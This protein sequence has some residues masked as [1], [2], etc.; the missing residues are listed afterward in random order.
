MSAPEAMVGR[1]DARGRL[2]GAVRLVVR[3]AV[4]IGFFT[5]PAV[6]LW[7][8]VWTG[9]PSSTLTCACGDPAQ[10]VWFVAWPAWAL[11]HLANPFFSGSVNVPFGANL[12]SNTSG[13]LIG[14]VL[15]PVTWVWGPVT[16]TNVALTLAPGLSAWGC[17]VA[18][19]RLVGWKP[20]A[21]PAA[22]VFGYSSAIVT[23]LIFAHASVTLLVIPPLLFAHFHQICIR[24]D[25][26]ALH[27]G[28]VLALLVVIQF[29]ISPE[30]LVMCVLL[31]AAGLVLVCLFGWRTVGER[32]PHAWRALAIGSVTAAVVLAYPAW[33]G[34]AGPQ[35][36]SGVLF[37][38]APLAGVVPGGFFSPGPYGELAGDYVRFGGYFG[39]IGPPP[40]YLGWGVGAAGA[41]ALL[42]AWRRPLVWLM[43]A[44]ALL[45]AWVALGSYILSGPAWIKHIPLPWRELSTWPVLKEI[46][47]DQFAPLIVFFVAVVVALGLS[48]ARNW[49][50]RRPRWSTWQVRWVSGAL[51]AA[52]AACTLIPV[53]ITFDMPF[54]VQS[55]DV[56][57]FMRQ[58]ALALPSQTV[59][60]T[61]PFAVS[62]STAPMLWQAVDGL[63]FRLAGAAL[64]T[65]G[66]HHNPVAQGAPG[67]ARRVLSDLSILSGTEP[68]GTPREYRALRDAVRRW[69]VDEVVIDGISRDPVYAAGFLTAA[70]G[71]APVVVNGA[72]VW[73]LSPGVPLEPMVTNTSLALCRAGS[74]DSS[75]SHNPLE[76]PRCV[77]QATPGR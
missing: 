67:S 6:A 56:P 62:G 68:T 64:K 75:P 4:R 66:A 51:M 50:A 57:P 18:I 7:W 74:L 72:W 61:V 71:R 3:H 24:Q 60:L 14:L 2:A 49:L 33:L 52:V 38:I 42:V 34:L 69:K 16:A 1:A 59:L 39:R 27:D 37:V 65:P 70:L 41:G 73:K 55:T 54:T 45:T 29:L 53:F 36:V 58:Q 12:E 46:L 10:E 25:S 20:A 40:N 22:L 17:W 35:S 15:S 43:A 23:S 63:H 5:L 11:S 76:M 31:G 9:H 28:L 32:A 30:V 19:R 8:H 44:M 26:S 21:V 13:T 77:L 47:P 48:A